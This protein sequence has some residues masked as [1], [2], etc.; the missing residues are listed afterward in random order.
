[1]IISGHSIIPLSSSVNTTLATNDVN[2]TK[3][4]ELHLPLL[5]NGTYMSAIYYPLLTYINTLIYKAPEIIKR[6]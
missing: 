2:I 6:I 5:G 3:N 4:R 1:M